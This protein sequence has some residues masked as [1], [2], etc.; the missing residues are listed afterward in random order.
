MTIH[1]LQIGLKVQALRKTK[2]MTN[3]EFVDDKKIKDILTY[4]KSIK[5]LG[6]TF[7]CIKTC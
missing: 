3:S 1:P 2:K 7:V 4:I 5:S 6:A